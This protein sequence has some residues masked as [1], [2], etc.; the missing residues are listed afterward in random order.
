MR[1]EHVELRGI[2][3]IWALAAAFVASGCGGGSSG[4]VFGS[5]LNAESAFSVTVQD[6]SDDSKCSVANGVGS[7]DAANANDVVVPCS[8]KL[9]TVGGAISGLTRTGLV[10]ANGANI[11]SVA[12]NT[13]S[14]SLPAPVVYTTSYA[15]T[16]ATQPAGLTCSVSNGSG[17]MPAGNVTSVKVKCL[18]N[19]YTVGGTAKDLNAKG[20]VL[21]LEL[22]RSAR[23]SR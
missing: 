14:F 20:L 2:G 9:Y 5:V 8:E 23:F 6:T 13:T 22:A 17:L 1:Y 12:A 19:A 7:T 16:V 11:V 10:L 18:D 15:V 21:L 4:P 3:V